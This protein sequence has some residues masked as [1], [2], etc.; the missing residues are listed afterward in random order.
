MSEDRYSVSIREAGGVIDVV[1]THDNTAGQVSLVGMVDH[2]M[3]N[4]DRWYA[5]MGVQRIGEADDP[6][7]LIGVLI[8]KH[9]V[10][11][12]EA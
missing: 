1:V 5:Y 2:T 4:P 10:E 6:F 7:S 11:R 12:E 9:V 8:A 3:S